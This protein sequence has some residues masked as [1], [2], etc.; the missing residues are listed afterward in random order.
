M[1]IAFARAAIFRPIVSSNLLTYNEKALDTT[2]AGDMIFYKPSCVTISPFPE[3]KCLTTIFAKSI[4][5][6]AQGVSEKALA[7]SA[8]ITKVSA[9]SGLMVVPSN[10]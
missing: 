2:E 5:Q 4:R 7:H 10:W 1:H 9:F 3:R 8:N 6:T